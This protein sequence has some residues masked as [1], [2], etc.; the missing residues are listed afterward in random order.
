MRAMKKLLSM[1]R[2]LNDPNL[3]GKALV[4]DSWL[5]WRVLLIAMMGEKLEP[6]ERAVFKQLTGRD[7]EP[8]VSVEEFAAVVGR[9]GGKSRALSVLAVYIAGLCKH[10]VV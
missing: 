3:L 5:P 9:R 1:R 6:D 4:G 7:H 2:A 10:P 8:G